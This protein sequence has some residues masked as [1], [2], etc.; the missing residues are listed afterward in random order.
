MSSR[1]ATRAHAAAR[2]TTAED[3]A[4][5]AS[6][7]TRAT[8]APVSGGGGGGGGSGGGG[9]GGGDLSDEGMQKMMAKLMADMQNPEF[10]ESLQ[11]SLAELSGAGARGWRHGRARARLQQQQLCCATTHGR[12]RV[13]EP[14]QTLLRP[15][16]RPR[17]TLQCL[18]RTDKWR[19][20]CRCISRRA[21]T[22]A[23][24]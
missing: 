5:A 21:L 23:H 6:A 15:R 2:G 1:I 14:V 13:R 22:R 9:G 8:V 17:P 4:I 19:A 16:P 12:P 3:V 7:A 20:H 18:R 24:S 10:A 11:K